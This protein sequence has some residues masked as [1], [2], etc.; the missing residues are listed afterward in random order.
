MVFLRLLLT[1]YIGSCL[2]W[3]LALIY[4]L[5]KAL[6][7]NQQPSWLQTIIKNGAA[8]EVV[9]FGSVMISP[10]ILLIVLILFLK[11]SITRRKK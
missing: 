3:S 11:E 2:L 4:Y 5:N 10:M 1:F 6:V 7:R 9:L 8:S